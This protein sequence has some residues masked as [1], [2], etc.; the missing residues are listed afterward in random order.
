MYE[1]TKNP[2]GDQHPKKRL[3][4]DILALRFEVLLTSADREW[5]ASM[6]IDCGHAK[7]SPSGS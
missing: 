2:A 4:Q 1:Q 5:L 7:W 3:Y 6:H